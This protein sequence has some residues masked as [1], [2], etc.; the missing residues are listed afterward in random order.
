MPIFSLFSIFYKTMLKNF[1]TFVFELIK[2]VVISLVI[3]IPIRY[4]LIQPFYVKGASM[5]P[6]FFDHEYLIIDEITYRFNEPQRG[7]IVVFR[8]P[9]NPQEFFIKRM[10]G[11]PGETLQIK[12]GVVTIFNSEKP[13]GFT[14]DEGYLPEGLK[15]Y[16]LSEEKITLSAD[17]YYVLGDNRNSSKDSRSFGPVNRTYIT[18]RVLLRGWPFNRIKLFEAPAY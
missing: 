10:I 9:R 7:D 1:F 18:G 14:L 12:D 5:E 15:T 17:E 8:Y 4:F 3:I 6:N 16:G 13:E 11:L 2:I